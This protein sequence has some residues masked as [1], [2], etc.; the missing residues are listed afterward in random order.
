MSF[1]FL[2]LLPRATLAAA[3]VGVGK[4]Q[5]WRAKIILESYQMRFGGQIRL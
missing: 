4:L 2:D 3:R 5:V 1:G